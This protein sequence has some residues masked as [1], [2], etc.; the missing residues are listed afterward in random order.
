MTVLIGHMIAGRM[1][2]DSVVPEWLR[3]TPKMSARIIILDCPECG[4][5][6]DIEHNRCTN[7]CDRD[8]EK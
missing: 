2:I 6:W 3:Y 8:L 4:G 7:Q 1:V 5:A